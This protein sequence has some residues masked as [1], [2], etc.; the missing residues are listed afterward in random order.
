MA[1]GGAGVAQAVEQRF[2]KP[3]V[4]GSI[5]AAGTI[6]HLTNVEIKSSITA[7]ELENRMSRDVKYDEL[8]AGQV[9]VADRG[10]TCM[11]EG[12]KTVHEDDDGLFV[13]CRH[14]RHYL[15]GQ[16]RVFGVLVGF[17]LSEAASS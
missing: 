15:D 14:G 6:F 1:Q 4:A 3:T 12:P 8:C 10:F 7:V 9:L 13:E 2:C 11:D 5:P 17:T 16:A